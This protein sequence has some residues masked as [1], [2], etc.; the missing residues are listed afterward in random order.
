MEHKRTFLQVHGYVTKNK[1]TKKQTNLESA[2]R[3]GISKVGTKESVLISLANC[4]FKY[5]A[6]LYIFTYPAPFVENIL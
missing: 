3:N 4:I 6:L 5:K 1:Q 2:C